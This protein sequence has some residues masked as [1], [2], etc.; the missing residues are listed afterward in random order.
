MAE[1]PARLEVED[2]RRNLQE[3]QALLERRDPRLVPELRARLEQLH[4]ADAAS[5]LESLAREERLAGWGL[6]R[7]ERGGG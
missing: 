4:A 3:V 5:I 1:L 6:V 7:G 2:L